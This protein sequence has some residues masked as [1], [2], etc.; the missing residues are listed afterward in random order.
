[1]DWV[2]PFLMT[3]LAGVVGFRVG[4]YYYKGLANQYREA[5]LREVERHQPKKPV[6]TDNVSYMDDYRK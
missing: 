1:M 6:Y 5:Y 3:S 2:A 4:S